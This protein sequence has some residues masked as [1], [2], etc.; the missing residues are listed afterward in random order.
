MRA[1]T[2]HE[3]ATKK[4]GQPSNYN[5]DTSKY[6]YTRDLQSSRQPQKKPPIVEAKET[7]RF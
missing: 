7:T 1:I 3:G 5:T 4:D 6:G 2:I